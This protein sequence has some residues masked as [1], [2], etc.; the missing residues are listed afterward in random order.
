MLKFKKIE[1]LKK[2]DKNLSVNQNT[3]AVTRRLQDIWLVVL[4]RGRFFFGALGVCSWGELRWGRRRNRGGEGRLRGDILTFTDGFTDGPIPSVILSARLTANRARHRM[5]LPFWIPRW[6]R[7]HFHRWIGHVTVRSWRF[8]SLG[9]SVGIFIGESVTSPYEVGVLNPSVIPSV[10]NTRNN[11]HISE[12]PFFFNSQHFVRNSI[13]IYR[14]NL[15][16]G[17]YRRNYQQSK[18]GR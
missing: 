11:L 7:R 6:F 3:D 2:T 16:V 12:P 4:R 18:F 1:L 14:R 15:S 9:D 10:K 17:I 5:E 8:E 13:D